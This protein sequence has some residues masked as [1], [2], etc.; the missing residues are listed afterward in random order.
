MIDEFA[1][2]GCAVET[3]S[4]PAP[5]PEDGRI[6]VARITTP[7]GEL[8]LVRDPVVRHFSCDRARADARDFGRLAVDRQVY[9]ADVGPC[10]RP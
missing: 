8:L 4:L 1:Y 6:A 10:Y 3:L 9:W 2:R 7:D 5:F